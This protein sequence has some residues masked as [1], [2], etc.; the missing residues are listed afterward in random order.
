MKIFAIG[1]I[2]GCY[3]SLTSLIADLLITKDDVLVFLGDY[4]DRGEHSEKVINFLVHIKE[5]AVFKTVFLKGNHEE[6]ILH[7][8]RDNEVYE[9]FWFDNGGRNTIKSYTH[10]DGFF[11]PLSHLHFF[12][13]LKLY[14]E[15][16]NY[17]FTHAGVD[18]GI[19]MHLQD[20]DTLLWTRNQVHIPNK[21]LIVGHTLVAEPY[22]SDIGNSKLRMIDTGCCFG[23]ALTAL[24][25]TTDTIYQVKGLK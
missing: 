3:A 15:I 24:E 21:T 5:K 23:N 16:G 17:I 13:D 22:F 7:W 18:L 1:D 4:I 2:H 6:F 10:K 9:K 8:L 25:V 19:P 11:L 12:N 20:S 14:Y